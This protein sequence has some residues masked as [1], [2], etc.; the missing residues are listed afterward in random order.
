MKQQVK[1]FFTNAVFG[2]TVWIV[3]NTFFYVVYYYISDLPKYSD[4]EPNGIS[5]TK[6]IPIY[7]VVYVIA[8]LVVLMVSTLFVKKMDNAFLTILSVSFLRLIEMVGLIVIVW[9]DDRL[10]YFV[11]WSMESL[12]YLLK[13]VLGIA[14][15]D[16]IL[17]YFLNSFIPFIM[18]FCGLLIREKYRTIRVRSETTEK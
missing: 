6:A 1:A 10:K 14:V 18:M 16:I 13:Y 8:L 3:F 15:S 5:F 4:F 17:L 11:N 7:A 12:T 2:E 9:H